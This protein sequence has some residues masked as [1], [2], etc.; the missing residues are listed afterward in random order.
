MNVTIIFRVL[1]LLFLSNTKKE[2][3]AY[4]L[5]T[6]SLDG[7]LA[8]RCASL[9][10]EPQRTLSAEQASAYLAVYGATRLRFRLVI[11]LKGRQKTPSNYG[12][13]DCTLEPGL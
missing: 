9:L 3:L 12:K 8:L 6:G 10:L 1:L 2:H 4:Q 7:R 5:A 13:K 11:G